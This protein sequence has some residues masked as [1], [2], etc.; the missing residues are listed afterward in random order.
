MTE[1]WKHVDGFDGAYSVSNYGRIRS[2]DRWYLRSDTLTKCFVQGGI[3]KIS[4]NRHGYPEVRVSYK[5]RKYSIRIH[6][7]VAKLFVENPDDKPQVN[8]IDGIKSNNFASNL[9]WVTNEENQKHAIETGLKKF[10]TG[11]GASRFQRTIIVLKDGLIVAEL[12]GNIEMAEFGL[13]YRL[14]SRCLK[15]VTRTHKGYTFKIKEGD[16]K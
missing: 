12:N 1:E 2:N 9:E 5:N 11:K 16:R 6:R 10:K 4:N 14:V 13:D 15:G 7:E 8:H 3:L